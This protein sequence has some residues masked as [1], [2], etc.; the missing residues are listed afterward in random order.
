MIKMD[1]IIEEDLR[2]M[3]EAELP[4]KMLAGKTVLVTGATG[5][6]AVYATWLLLYLHEYKHIN[7]NV[8]ALCR[9]RLKAEQYFAQFIGKDYFCILLQDV[10]LPI[11]YEGSVNYVFHLAGNASP[12][13]ITTDPVGIMKC[14]LQGTI[15]V[16][17]LAKQKKCEKIL[18]AS[19]REV[20]GKNESSESM[21]EKD[22]GVLDPLDVRSCYPESKRAAE[23]LLRSYYLQYGINYNILRIAHAYGPTMNLENDGRVMADFMSDIVKK[24]NIVIKSQGDAIRAFIYITDVVVGMFTALFKG[25]DATAY[26]LANEQEPISIKDLAEL[27]TN[28]NPTTK[29]IIN[30]PHDNEKGYCTYRRK[31]LNTKA[32]EKIGWSPKI[33]LEEGLQRTYFCKKR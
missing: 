5:M 21:T 22:F 19:T 25:E 8:V 26:N 12:Y 1:N 13:F 23:T 9:N 28:L 17:E 33:S 20:Y 7:V 6:L 27:L 31:A 24:R 29:V 32:L 18:F 16:L 10:C 11:Q 3:Y 14:N 30:I 4:W 15:S 2:R